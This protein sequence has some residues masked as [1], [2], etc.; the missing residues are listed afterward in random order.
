MEAKSLIDNAG[1]DSQSFR[2]E[3]SRLS[4][5]VE[6]RIVMSRFSLR[7]WY[8]NVEPVKGTSNIASVQQK[9]CLSQKVRLNNMR[10]LSLCCHLSDM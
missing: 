10:L 9:T 8:I 3:F 7:H 4:A 5:W 6:Y 2:G 1:V